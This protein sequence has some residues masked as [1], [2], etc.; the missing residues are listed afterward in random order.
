MAAWM[1]GGMVEVMALEA[2][3]KA[4]AE[5]VAEETDWLAPKAAEARQAERVLA[6]GQHACKRRSTAGLE[7]QYRLD[8]GFD[9]SC[10]VRCLFHIL[11]HPRNAP[12]RKHLNTAS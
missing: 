5:T 12:Q 2:E 1:E 9:S 10:L 4:A 3:V 11:H 8:S 6:L 7:I